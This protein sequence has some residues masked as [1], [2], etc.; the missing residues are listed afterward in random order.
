MERTAKELVD[1]SAEIELE[2]K[3]IR[4]RFGM[5]KQKLFGPELDLIWEK[6]NYIQ[7]ST[8]GEI[9]EEVDKKL[10]QL[11]AS[12][13]SQVAYQEQNSKDISDVAGNYKRLNQGVSNI[14]TSMQSKLGDLE[15]RV[16]CLNRGINSN[17]LDGNSVGATTA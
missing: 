6:L 2:A 16:A 9:L 1:D 11:T 7:K 13:N 8:R 4:S 17:T 15:H 14:I 10:Q 5:L 3:D 12:I